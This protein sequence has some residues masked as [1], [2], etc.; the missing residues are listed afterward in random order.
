MLN[1]RHLGCSGSCKDCWSL[2]PMAVR[3]KYTEG[4]ELSRLH[5]VE[6][7]VDGESRKTF[8]MKSVFEEGEAIE[9]K[10]NRTT[11]NLG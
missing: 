10:Y 6:A 7:E 9:K 11:A 5:S 3:C 1:Q 4:F 2:D 8:R